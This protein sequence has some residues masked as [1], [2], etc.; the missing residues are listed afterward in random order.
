MLCVDEENHLLLLA[1]HTRSRSPG[2][3]GANTYRYKLE[4][5]SD[6]L[7]CFHK[8]CLTSSISQNY[9]V[10]PNQCYSSKSLLKLVKLVAS[11]QDL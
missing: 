4:S 9:P 2:V 1:A 11:F 3:R 10:A 5:L 6:R 8:V 7:N